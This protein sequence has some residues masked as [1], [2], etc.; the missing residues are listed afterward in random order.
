MHAICQ[1][2]HRVYCRLRAASKIKPRALTNRECQILKWVAKGKRN[3]VIAYIIGISS[4]T[5]NGYLRS[6]YLKTGTSDRTSAAL[7]GVSEALIDF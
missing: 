1:Y 2:A 4:H 5:V 3:S 7:R 6:I